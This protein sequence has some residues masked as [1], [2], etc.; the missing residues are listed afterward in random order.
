MSK[1][2][3][4]VKG[5]VGLSLLAS[6]VGCGDSGN[7]PNRPSDV[8][9]EVSEGMAT[10]VRVSWRTHVP[11]RGYVEYGP[12][13]EL[14]STTPLETDP[15]REHSA[16]LLGLRDSTEYSY[17]VVTW[18]GAN[19]GASEIRSVRTESLPSGLPN[20]DVEG[21]GNDRYIVV[22]ILG[23]KPAVAILDPEGQL[24]WYRPDDSGLDVF[25]ARLSVDG[26]CILYSASSVA[27]DP[28]DD[29][30]ITRVSLDGTETSRI[31]VPLLAHDFV[32]HEDGTLGA[33]VVEY[34]DVDGNQVRGDKIVEIDPDGDETTVW[35]SWDCFDP[36]DA[37]GE[38]PEADWTF[39]N[40]LDYD[41]KDD[42]YYLGMRSFSS[43]VKISRETGECE[44][45]L[46][47]TAPTL[48]F[49]EG[50]KRF[51]H[52]HQF[53]VNGNHI[54]VMDNDGSTG[55]ERQSRVIEYE[56]DFEEETATEVWSYVADPPVHTYVL[57]E[58]NRL[59]DGSTF[60]NWSAAGQM[61][62]VDEDGD[63]TWKLTSD[64][65]TAFGFHTL[66]ETLYT[67]E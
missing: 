21:D 67:R 4:V 25:R 51:L 8:S 23:Q 43:I 31:D 53:E 45:V 17:R 41:A 63:V 30:H 48:E 55:V 61:E 16:L 62:R 22:P 18:D 40:A 13:E 35:T 38:D 19:A 26:K 59:S 28:E 54:L 66:A 5:L 50:S 42:A 57:G 44:W 15:T 33:I 6:A 9:A 46:G 58:P 56:L 10:V 14:G 20:I 37:P 29:T 11:T 12:D 52:E 1:V 60:I 39:G 34:R 64:L 27:G 32:E 7:D 49:A 47:S 36:A 2:R 24:V 65:G 3:P